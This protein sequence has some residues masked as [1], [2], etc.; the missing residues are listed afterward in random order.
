MFRVFFLNSRRAKRGALSVIAG[1]LVASA[2][3]RLGSDAG[4]AL[5]RTPEEKGVPDN[6]SDMAVTHEMSMSDQQI[7]EVLEA[8][9][10]RE[11]RLDQREAALEDRMVALRVAD[12][13]VSAKLEELQQAETA[14]RQTIVLAETASESDIDRLTKVYESMKPK[15]AAALFQEMDPNFAAGFLGRM[16]PEAAAAVMAGLS[17]DAAHMFSVV[18]AGRN[19]NVP[20]E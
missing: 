10:T 16:R 18:L 15:Q 9:Q 2:L 12:Q 14:L 17:P 20:K 11:N 8:F 5:A 3:V 4:Q 19:A 1:L 7:A 13:Q 6:A